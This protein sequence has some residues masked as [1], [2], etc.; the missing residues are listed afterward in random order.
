MI[1]NS[2]NILNSTEMNTLNDWIAQYVV[3][4]TT[5]LLKRKKY[6]HVT[7]EDR[8]L[9]SKTVDRKPAQKVLT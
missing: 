9:E 8:M 5:K 4:V 1:H 3:Y 6:Y 2:L 7:V